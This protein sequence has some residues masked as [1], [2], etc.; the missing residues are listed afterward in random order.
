[1]LSACNL[2]TKTFKSICSFK[3]I[4]F[5]TFAHLAANLAVDIV[6]SNCSI[7]EE[8]FAIKIFY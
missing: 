7:S 2:F 5:S 1:M 4:S 3:C 6:S 8:T